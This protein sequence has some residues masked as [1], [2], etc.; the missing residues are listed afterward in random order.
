MKS[1]KLTMV[2]TAMLLSTQAFAQ[3]TY[4]GLN[5][6][7]PDVGSKG[8]IN[9]EVEMKDIL[10]GGIASSAIEDSIPQLKRQALEEVATALGASAGLSN[11]M[12]ERRMEIEANSAS[13]DSVFDFKKLTIDNGV[14]AP[15]LAEGIS[16]YAQDSDDEIR[17]SDK[18][19]K[20]EK[21]ARFVSVYPTWRD[22]LVFSFP[23][24]EK[25]NTAYLPVTDAEKKVWDAAVKKGWAKGRRQADSIVEAS[26][27]RLDR[28]Y[29]GMILY[30]LLLAE[31]LVTPTVIAKQNLGVTGGGR[32]MAV[33]DQV[34]RITDHSA[35]NPNSKDWKV[36]YPITNNVN[37]QLK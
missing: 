18:I 8:Q 3:T 30:K 9:Q 13:L 35:L 11:R 21:P 36:E 25:P 19:Y 12:K 20:I 4:P 22:Y 32:E 27:N 14:L 37:G 33:N 28:D 24:Y 34:F 15:V 7:Q 17:V 29:N 5:Y 6:P 10:S 1:L 2:A 31:G 23:S 16:N 26:Y